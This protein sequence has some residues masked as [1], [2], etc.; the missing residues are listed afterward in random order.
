MDK[1]VVNKKVVKH[2]SICLI[3]V[4]FLTATIVVS[5]T[6]LKEEKSLA[7]GVENICDEINS[8]ILE[9]SKVSPELAMSSNPFDYIEKSKGYE[10]LVDLGKE[11]IPYIL[12]YMENSDEGLCSYMLAVAMEDISGLDVYED[13]G[14][15]WSTSEEFIKAWRKTENKVVPT[16]KKME[17]TKVTRDVPTALTLNRAFKN[18]FK[19]YYKY[20]DC[21][22]CE[23]KYDENF[24]DDY[25][26]P[27]QFGVKMCTKHQNNI[28]DEAAFYDYGY[29]DYN[30]LA[31]ALGDTNPCSW[32][33]PASWGSHPGKKQVERYFKWRSYTVEDYDKDK[34]EYYKSKR[35][36][37]VYGYNSTIVNSYIIT[38]FGRVDDINGNL[39]Q[40]ADTVS[41]WGTGAIYTTKSANPYNGI[42]G[43]GECVMVCY[44]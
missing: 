7:A 11:S 26:N 10:K 37:F 27:R 39:V 35:A 40:G 30:C 44:K 20:V 22:D 12:S 6:V 1:S 3:V 41:K 32:K 18:N 9:M 31:Y 15:D 2:F 28:S 13:T 38:H 17:G 34:I 16:V 5:M 23:T 33:W 14:I 21:K 43:Y 29:T 25:G 19:K 42:N 4:L 24:K 8:D 36:I